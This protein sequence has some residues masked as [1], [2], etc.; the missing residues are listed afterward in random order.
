MMMKQKREEVREKIVEKFFMKM[1]IRKYDRNYYY[2][3]LKNKKLK[4][5]FYKPN[6]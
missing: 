2:Q 4:N 3:K 6:R 1:R 5:N